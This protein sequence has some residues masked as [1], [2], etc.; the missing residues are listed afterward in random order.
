VF[1]RKFGLVLSCDVDSI[2]SLAA[3]VVLSRDQE[4]LVGYKIGF[5]LSLRFGLRA[6][7]NTVRELCDLPI[8]YDHQKAGTDIPQMGNSFAECCSESGVSGVIV[9]PQSGPETLS[10]FV[11]AIAD[12]GM[13]PIV[14][15]LMTHRAYLQSDGGFIADNAPTLIYGKALELG[16][17]HFVVPGNQTEETRGY[18][19][20]MSRAQH[21]LSFLMPGI[22]SQGG[23]IEDALDAVAGHRGYAIVG[24]AIYAAEDPRRALMTFTEQ[25]NAYAIS[26]AKLEGL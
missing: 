12:K 3:L 11:N 24:S 13:V 2:E 9:F 10:A 22:G 5:T 7:I 26:N 20:M 1:E 19:A 6:V 4:V 17:S 8:I 25:I 14:G 16:V 23:R 21:P 18:V 15:G